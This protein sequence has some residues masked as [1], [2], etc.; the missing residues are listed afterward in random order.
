MLSGTFARVTGTGGYQRL[1]ASINPIFPEANVTY[2]QLRYEAGMEP[3]VVRWAH[4]QEAVGSAAAWPASY[5]TLIL[6]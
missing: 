5:T 3:H 2:I 4:L 6:Q 1:S